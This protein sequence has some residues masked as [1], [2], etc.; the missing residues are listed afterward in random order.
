MVFSLEAVPV[1]STAQWFD[2]WETLI[3]PV[4][5]ALIGAILNVLT[6]RVSMKENAK[7]QNEA[8]EHQNRLTQLTVTL[9]ISKSIPLDLLALVDRLIAGETVEAIKDEYVNMLNRIY[10]YASEAAVRLALELQKTSKEVKSD[11]YSSQV[12]LA[13]VALLIAQLRMDISG[14]ALNART[15]LGMRANEQTDTSGYLK[16]AFEDINSIG[17]KLHLDTRLYN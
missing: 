1:I 15:W 16:E 5:I 2:R 7:R 9:D 17:K 13:I 6:L 4:L 10:C 12:T 14:V 3:V 8:L 11:Q